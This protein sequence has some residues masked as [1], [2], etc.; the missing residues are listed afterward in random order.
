MKFEIEIIKGLQKLSSPFLDGVMRVVAYCFDY[1]LVIALF[2][3]LLIFKKKIESLLF[4]IIEGVGAGLQLLLKAII[5]RPRPYLVSSDVRN[6]L[7]ASNS[8]FPS[9]HSVTCMGAA[10]VLFYIT[11]KSSLKK[12]YKVLCYMG[13]I[14]MLVLCAFNRMYLG[15]HHITDVIGGFSLSLIIG[16]AVILVYN[17]VKPKLMK[18]RN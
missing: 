3:I 2:L 4:L 1:P 5:D 15:Q 10:L 18:V 14:F 11:Y 7:E 9:G 8:A 6:I 12:G 17:H 16:V 13:L